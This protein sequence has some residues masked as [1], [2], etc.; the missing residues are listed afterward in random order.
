VNRA[1]RLELRRPRDI[2]ALFGDALGVYFRHFATF[3]AI[4]AAI[5][6]PAQLIVSGIGLE[7][8]TSPYDASP[9]PAEVALPTLVSF[10]VTAPLITA[11]CIYALRAVAED[12]PPRAGRAIAAGL[13]SFTPI[14]V[15]VLLAAV[16]I[17][18]GLA[19]LVIPGVYLAVRWYFVPQVVVLEGARR[20]DALRR[21]GEVVRGFWWRTLGILLL[22]NLAAVVPGLLLAA[23]F[24]ALADQ[25]DRELYALIGTVLTET[26]TTP[27]VALL[28]I[29]LYYD[30]KARRA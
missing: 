8:L 2:S 27:F 24:T 23:P 9:S 21:S 1:A 14:F 17:A 15:A 13:E 26:V 19:L 4:S 12:P 22:G 16:G 10:L 3:F 18:L 11:I 5:V 28:S 29:L 30:L 20:V 25:A 6:I 7:Q